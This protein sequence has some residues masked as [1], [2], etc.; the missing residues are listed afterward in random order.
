MN[1]LPAVN[2]AGDAAETLALVCDALG[3]GE[4][5]A[6]STWKMVVRAILVMAFSYPLFLL[7]E[8]VR[9]N[10]QRSLVP[11]NRLRLRADNRRR[12]QE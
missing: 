9:R 7:F 1:T 5:I 3:I 8:L 11:W 2:Q 12:P 6:W 4:L 10:A